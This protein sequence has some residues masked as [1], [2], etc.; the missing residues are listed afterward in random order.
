MNYYKRRFQY[1]LLVQKDIHLSSLSK[2]IMD[3][4]HFKCTYKVVTKEKGSQQPEPVRTH[5]DD[6]ISRACY[7]VSKIQ[8]TD[9]LLKV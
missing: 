8:Q 2:S 4:S 6:D 3:I 7:Y 5:N 1:S 9:K